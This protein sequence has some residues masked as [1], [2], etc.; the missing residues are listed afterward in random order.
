MAKEEKDTKRPLCEGPLNLVLKLS[1]VFGMAPLTFVPE[2][3]K[4]SLVYYIC[5]IAFITALETTI[6]VGFVMEVTYPKQSRRAATTH[7]IWLAYQSVLSAV[8]LVGCFTAPKRCRCILDALTRIEKIRNFL[9][10]IKSKQIEAIY[11]YATIFCFLSAVVILCLIDWYQYLCV[12]FYLNNPVSLYPLS[13]YYLE[14]I[15]EILLEFQFAIV[16]IRLTVILRVV[17]SRLSK[18]LEGM[19]RRKCGNKKPLINNFTLPK[20]ILFNN[21]CHQMEVYEEQASEEIRVLWLVYELVCDLIRRVDRGF[22]LILL[23]LLQS[24]F[25]HFIMTPYYILNI[26]Q[27]PSG[28]SSLGHQVAWFH[29]HAASVILIV[30]PCHRVQQQMSKTRSLVSKLMCQTRPN[31]SLSRSLAAFFRSLTLEQP[32]IAPLGMSVLERPLLI[33]VSAYYT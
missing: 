5:S 6:L 30:E 21:D 17:N 28:L 25:L 23:L 11:M 7:I 33:T 13:S 20:N 19:D 2:G 26:S 4:F 18:L 29:F 3:I 32:L 31:D 1:R 15:I 27:I 24:F 10:E 14:Y 12:P 8:T 22:G 9:G 16:V